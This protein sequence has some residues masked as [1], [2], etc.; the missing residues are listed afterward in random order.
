MSGLESVSFGLASECVEKGQ[1]YT[2][3]LE[4]A[5]TIAEKG[6]IALRMAKKAI[7][8]GVEMGIDA[9]L[10]HEKKCYRQVI[11]TSDRLEGLKAFVEKRKPVYRG[12]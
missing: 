8:E 10:E 3:A 4:I 2:R 9:S 6:P 12:V 7:D 5:T 1:A 11:H